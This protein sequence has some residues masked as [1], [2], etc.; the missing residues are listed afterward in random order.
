MAPFLCYNIFVFLIVK[1]LYSVL[2]CV[3]DINKI[4]VSLDASEMKPVRSERPRDFVSFCG[5]LF[6]HLVFCRTLR[7]LRENLEEEAV[8]MKDVPGWKVGFDYV[9]TVFCLFV[10]LFFVLFFLEFMFILMFFL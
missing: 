2:F 9:W 3:V 6:T 5:L 7:M 10:C 1:P 4:K 8:I